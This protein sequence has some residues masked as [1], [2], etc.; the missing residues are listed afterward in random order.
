MIRF[1]AIAK[2][3]DCLLQCS[4]AEKDDGEQERERL[5]EGGWKEV[6]EINE[7][8]IEGLTLCQVLCY[9]LSHDYL[10]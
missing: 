9:S 7:H 4:D 2:R 6:M 1:T 8:F 3:L 5:S 10:S